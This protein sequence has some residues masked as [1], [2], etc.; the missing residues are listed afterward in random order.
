MIVNVIFLVKV[1]VDCPVPV[2]VKV[3]VPKI[4]KVPVAATTRKSYHCSAGKQPTFRL[5]KPQAY[6]TIQL[7]QPQNIYQ[8]QH[9]HPHPHQHQ[10]QHLPGA[11]HQNHFTDQFYHN[12]HQHFHQHD[13]ANHGCTQRVQSCQLVVIT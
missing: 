12:H 2:P 6:G 10:H 3:P 9:Q 8:H 13:P 7:N 1:P 11:V 4:V 5:N